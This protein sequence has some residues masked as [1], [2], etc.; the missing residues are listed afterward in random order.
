[1]ELLN[2]WLHGQFLL[3]F[4]LDD[5]SGA[6]LAAQGLARHGNVARLG[7][8]I[9]EVLG[10]RTGKSAP[11]NSFGERLSHERISQY[12]LESWSFGGIKDENLGNEVPGVIGDGDMLR[13]SIVAGLDFL[14]GSLDFRCLEGR[15]SN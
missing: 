12:F 13:E 14:V 8:L 1:M 2:G 9:H 3:R 10:G 15:F 6:G 11:R 4:L 5:L 7:V